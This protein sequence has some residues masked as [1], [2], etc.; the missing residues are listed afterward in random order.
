MPAHPGRFASAKPGTSSGGWSRGTPPAWR[1]RGEIRA[2]ATLVDVTFCAIADVG[3][4]PTVST[5]REGPAVGRIRFV[6]GAFVLL[7]EIERQLS[8]AKALAAAA[9]PPRAA[10][11]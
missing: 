7:V 11:M 1:P 5:L 4:I 6:C 8:P 3:S 2:P 9:A 10:S